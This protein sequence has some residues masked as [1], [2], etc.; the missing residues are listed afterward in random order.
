MKKKYVLIILASIV[1]GVLIGNMIKDLES[2]EVLYTSK[3]DIAKKEIKMTNKSIKK[4]QNE[5]K[6]L[7]KEINILREKYTDIDEIKKMDDMKEV[8]SYT[9]IKGKGITIIIDALNEDIGNIANTVDY[10]KI[11]INL[12]NELKINGGKFI[13]INGQRI[14]QYSAIILAGSHINVNSIPIA[15]PYE[16]KVIGDID[17]LSSYVNEGNN[18]I[19]NIILN[20][21]M[22]VEYKV[23]ESINMPKIEIPNKLR[24]IREG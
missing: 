2:M 1:L 18:Y 17:K 22:K 24:Y 10:N 3:D 19:D 5:R 9:D 23:E 12:V 7:D 4:L 20:Y 21:P 11:L 14:N 6:D 8:L 15:Q 13:S 16:I